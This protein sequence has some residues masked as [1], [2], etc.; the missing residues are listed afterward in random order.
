MWNVHEEF[1]LRY[2]KVIVLF[3]YTCSF[4]DLYNSD[5]VLKSLYL[6]WNLGIITNRYCTFTYQLKSPT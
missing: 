3:I 6:K 4:L 2:Q 1:Q 5:I